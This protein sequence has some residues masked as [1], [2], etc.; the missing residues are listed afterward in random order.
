MGSE[1]L[2]VGEGR[3]RD[4]RNVPKRLEDQKVS[5]ASLER[6]AD[7]MLELVGGDAAFG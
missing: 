1:R 6:S 3:W 5:I 4:D 7:P 2:S